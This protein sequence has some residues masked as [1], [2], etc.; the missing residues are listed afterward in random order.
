MKD[1][2]LKVLLIIFVT[3]GLLIFLDLIVTGLTSKNQKPLSSTTQ[4]SEYQS[5]TI[6][7]GTVASSTYLIQKGSTT[8]GSAIITSS[9]NAFSLLNWNNTTSTVS[10]TL[11]SFKASVAE[12]T[13]TFDSISNNG[14]YL[15]LPATTTGNI[16]VTYR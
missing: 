1:K 8:F 15:V 6:L 14:L 11:A 12:G 10:T 5:K 2:I 3:I 13:Y 16:T 4:G 9:T 7:A